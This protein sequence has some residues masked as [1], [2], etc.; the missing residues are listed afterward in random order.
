[1][2]RLIILLSVILFFSGLK[3]ING[4][5]ATFNCGKTGVDAAL[6]PVT[7]IPS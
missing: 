3:P 5:T 6:A 4:H 1:M 7:R 2:T